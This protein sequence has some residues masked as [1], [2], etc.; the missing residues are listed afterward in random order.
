MITNFYLIEAKI[1]GGDEFERVTAPAITKEIMAKILQNGY[2]PPTQEWIS[3]QLV[4]G[5]NYFDNRVLIRKLY[6]LDSMTSE[7][8]KAAFRQTFPAHHEKTARNIKAIFDTLAKYRLIDPELDSTGRA[9]DYEFPN[10]TKSESVRRDKISK[11]RA[12]IKPILEK[13]YKTPLQKMEENLSAQEY[14]ASVKYIENQPENLQKAFAVFSQ[15]DAPELSFLKHLINVREDAKKDGYTNTVMDKL[16]NKKTTASYLNALGVISE[17]GVLNKKLTDDIMTLLSD[18]N[19]AFSVRPIAIEFYQTL[20]RLSSDATYSENALT[21]RMAGSVASL[22]ASA[23]VDNMSD[24]QKSDL[25]KLF[26]NANRREEVDVLPS[27]LEAFRKAGLI[28]G[29]KN[30]FTDKGRAV[31]SILKTGGDGNGGGS[32]GKNVRDVDS[33]ASIG[34]HTRK[35]SGDR[36]AIVHDRSR[37]KNKNIAD[38]GSAIANVPNEIGSTGQD[39]TTMKPSK[40]NAGD[41]MKWRDNRNK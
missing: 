20:K 6:K 3:G 30:Q 11:L 29:Q 4:S 9:M 10:S 14:Q 1:T 25:T 34:D 8:E 33:V 27:S 37:I 35:Q 7:Q 5:R 26:L 12:Q 15:M 32:V 19:F 38:K 41:F 16:A 22:D 28:S 31:A 13:F 23:F 40:F 18:R 24:Q 39:S 2:I 21:K 36:D 17:T